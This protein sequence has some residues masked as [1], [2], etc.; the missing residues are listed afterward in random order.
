MKRRF[1][2]SHCY[3]KMPSLNI[4]ALPDMVFILILFFAASSHIRQG[5]SHS[6]V[7]MP[8]ASEIQEVDKR[9]FV[10][11]ITVKNDSVTK[12]PGIWID[13][14][15]V[16]LKQVFSLMKARRV[17]LRP[18]DSPY[19][20]ASLSIDREIPMGIVSDIKQALRRANVLNICYAA[21]PE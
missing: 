10:V 12:Q 1:V 16:I 9:A 14:K 21:I 7:S 8:L 20:V 3:N 19:L 5:N 18:A 11:Y 6:V 2:T 13:N 17:S 15:R 4:F